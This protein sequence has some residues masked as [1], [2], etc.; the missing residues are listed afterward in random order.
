[1]QSKIGPIDVDD[2]V[3]EETAL[4]VL[5]ENGITYTAQCGGVGCTHPTAIGFVLPLGRIGEAI[6]DCS[7]GCASLSEYNYKRG[8]MIQQ[9]NALADLIDTHLKEHTK[10]WRFSLS[11]DYSR[12]NELQEGWWPVI[13]NGVYDDFHGTTFVHHPGIIHVGN[14]D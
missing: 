1:M 10:S 6:D 13:I 5:L 7:F 14:C 8:K 2:I 12:I 3:R 4:I 9:R 11:F